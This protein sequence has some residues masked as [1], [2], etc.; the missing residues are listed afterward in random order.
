MNMPTDEVG[1]DVQVINLLSISVEGLRSH[2]S[3]L[4]GPRKRLRGVRNDDHLLENSRIRGRDAVCLLDSWPES[5]RQHKRSTSRHH[6]HSPDLVP[7]LDDR[8]GVLGIDDELGAGFNE[9]AAFVSSA[10]EHDRTTR[11][12]AGRDEAFLRDRYNFLARAQ[13]DDIVLA[14]RARIRTHVSGMLVRA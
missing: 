13:H 5:P 14:S 10:P 6:E 4:R 12:R 9:N 2:N 1:R 7:E 3:A 8:G 11:H